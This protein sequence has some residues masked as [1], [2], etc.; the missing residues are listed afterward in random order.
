[1]RKRAAIISVVV[2]II[3]P[4]AVGIGLDVMA[5]V[6]EPAFTLES[7]DGEFEV[8]R[9]GARVLAETTVHGERDRAA[10]EG[11]RRLAGYIFGG[12]KTNAKIAMTAPVGQTSQGRKLAM[13]APVGQRPGS[14]ASWTVS[15]TMPQ[16]ETL[17][18]LPAPN[19]SRV[20]LHE[21]PPARV[22]V[23]KFS[24]RWTEESFTRHAELLRAW[25][26]SR[27]L[28]TSGDAEVN[29]YDPPW[30]LWFMRRNE[31]WLRLEQ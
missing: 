14:G 7:R 26:S 10:S 6:D 21:A 17:A 3:A 22:G 20:T 8:R 28:T 5:K 23:V 2:V 19:D 30:T 9:Y 29:R 12:N 24:G 4:A 25:L 16:G 31:I 15:F 1:M 11:F 13:T 18:T 27:G